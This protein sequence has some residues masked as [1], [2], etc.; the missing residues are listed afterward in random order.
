MFRYLVICLTLHSLLLCPF[1]C[2]SASVPVRAASVEAAKCDAVRRQPAKC[3]CCQPREEQPAQTG[4]HSSGEDGPQPQH[5]DESQCGCQCLCQGALET[6][7]VLPAAGT[8]ASGFFAIADA[9]LH[10]PQAAGLLGL[11]LGQ[12]LAAGPFDPALILP[13]Q[14]C[15]LLL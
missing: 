7:L 1:R 3:R 9:V 6:R 10:P 8:V 4:T 11:S 15:A 13:L 12:H 2:L 14:V 5:S